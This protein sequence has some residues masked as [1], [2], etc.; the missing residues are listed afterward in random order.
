MKLRPFELALVVIFLVLAIAALIILARYES[1]P[2]T[3]D[4]ELQAIGTVAVWGT[5]PLDGIESLL[6]ELR[7]EN[8]A[9][10]NVSYRYLHPDEFDEELLAALA[11]GVGPD[12]V[13]MSHEKLVDMRRRIDP[14][15]Y[16]AFPQVDF[17]NVYVEGAQVFTLSDGIY[18]FP[19]AVDPL[20]MYW[21]R[22]IYATE[23]FLEPA[24]TWESFVNSIFPKLIQRDFDRTIN[25][26]VVAM[27][28]YNNVR[29]SFGIISM[30]ML[31]GGTQG[32]LSTDDGRY[33]IKLQVSFGENG[34][35]L[36]NAAD[37]YTRFSQPSNSWYSWNRAFTEDRN[38]FLAE[39]LAT[40]FG[41][42]S[43]GRIIE[44]MNPNLNFDIAE[45]PQ[46]A[47]ATLRRTYGKFY[48]LAVLSSSDN[49]AGAN[50]VMVNLG[51]APIADQIAVRSNMVPVYRNS[52][53][54]G[55]NDSFGR[56]AYLS[57]PITYGWLNPNM[58]VTDQVF[59]TMTQDINEN[60][61]DLGGAVNDVSGRLKNEY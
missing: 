20:M 31:Q 38:E 22:D 17:R 42:A 12:L 26:A 55:S 39:D 30:L 6:K 56:A 28:E 44:R 60:R 54:Q 15:S 11:D 27:G 59:S 49:K 58:K 57:A 5:I 13:L 48:T 37:F 50:A 9:Y 46:D 32:V 19:I 4:G 36:H 52:V 47:N 41:Y 2:T 24:R 45:V 33:L 29:N 34:D 21:N 40:Y 53:S 61:R 16:E 18:G 1:Q 3:K 43:E 7:D 51:S 8:N 25:R 14:I 23:G 35:P 10:R